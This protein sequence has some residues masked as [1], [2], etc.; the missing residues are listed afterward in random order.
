[1]IIT[2]QCSLSFREE[3]IATLFLQGDDASKVSKDFTAKYGM[4]EDL[5]IALKHIV[6]QKMGIT[7]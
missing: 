4:R 2:G 7:R 6:C 5:S 1:M 3:G